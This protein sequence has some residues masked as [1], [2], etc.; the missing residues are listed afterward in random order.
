MAVARWQAVH[1]QSMTSGNP[2]VGEALLGRQ[3]SPDDLAPIKRICD[4]NKSE[5]GFVNRGA[6]AASI[7]R[8]EILC[9]SLEGELCGFVE[10]HHR[11]DAQTTLYHIG[12]AH[13]VRGQ[14]VGAALV[15]SLA[16]ESRRRDKAHIRLKCPSTLEANSFYARL[17]FQPLGIEDGKS[18]PLQ[19]WQLSV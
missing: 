6:L 15:Q 19:I 18:T 4:A 9:A 1:R 10:Y 17:G 5:L 3:A 13:E 14:G 12:V 8:G 7:E 16:A 2:K 11:R